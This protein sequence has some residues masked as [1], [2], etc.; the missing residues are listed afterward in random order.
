MVNVTKEKKD[1]R[2]SRFEIVLRQCRPLINNPSLQ[3]DLIK[4]V[5]SKEATEVAKS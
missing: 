1:D 5:A 4:L 3:Q 2:A